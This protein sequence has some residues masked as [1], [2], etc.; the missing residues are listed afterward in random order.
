MAVL[1]QLGINHTIFFQLGIFLFTLIVLGGFVFT[2]FLRLAEQRE[3]RT[4]GGLGDA[5]SLRREA[6]E[7]REKYEKCARDL[8][9]ET[10]SIFEAARAQAARQS[11]EEI[12]RER[13]QLDAHIKEFRRELSQQ[14]EAAKR[15]LS[16]GVPELAGAIRKKISSESA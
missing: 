9:S 12:S 1:E 10:R 2:P 13:A 16:A 4:D 11:S 5:D 15:D 3:A 7:L 8:S 6:E 14:V